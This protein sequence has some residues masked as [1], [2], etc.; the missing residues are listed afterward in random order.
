MTA[1]FIVINGTAILKSLKKITVFF[2]DIALIGYNV[3]ERML[4]NVNQGNP[5]LR[6]R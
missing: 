1:F 2:D 4:M 3:K 5:I 6:S